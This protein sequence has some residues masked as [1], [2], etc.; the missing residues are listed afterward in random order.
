MPMDGACGDGVGGGT[1]QSRDR[2]A[3]SAE[4][5][6]TEGA[7]EKEMAFTLVVL[8]GSDGDSSFG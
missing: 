1:A 2:F 6:V 3:R 5:D 4:Y 8:Y 7:V